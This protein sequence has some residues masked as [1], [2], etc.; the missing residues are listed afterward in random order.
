MVKNLEDLKKRRESIR[1]AKLSLEILFAALFIT[2]TTYNK[3]EITQ[4]SVS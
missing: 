4:I 2:A 1:R 3:I